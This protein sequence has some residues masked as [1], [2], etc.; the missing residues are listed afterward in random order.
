MFFFSKEAR[1]IFPEPEGGKERER[2][3]GG[4]VTRE[5]GEAKILSLNRWVFFVLWFF[6]EIHCKLSH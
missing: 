5:E 1:W 6:V 4:G 2:E 3:D